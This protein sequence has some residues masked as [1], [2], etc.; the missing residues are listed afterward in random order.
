MNGWEYINRTGTKGITASCPEPIV[1]RLSETAT[2]VADA[3]KGRYGQ[4]R[5]LWRETSQ[6]PSTVTMAISG[7]HTSKTVV[8][9]PIDPEF[10]VTASMIHG[11]NAHDVGTRI[12]QNA[13]H[14]RLPTGS[15][16]R[17][18]VDERTPHHEYCYSRGASVRSSAMTARFAA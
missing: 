15:I 7:E 3:A 8:L 10:D 18:L 2:N 1:I 14:P 12:S 17:S 6:K 11:T 13:R 9:V 16:F 5:T 4:R